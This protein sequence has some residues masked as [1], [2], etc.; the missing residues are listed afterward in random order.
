MKDKG[1][2]TLFSGIAKTLRKHSPEVL[3]GIGIAGMVSS[4]VL[5]V[6][7]TPKAMKLIEKKKSEN[8]TEKIKPVEVFKTSW[9]CYIPTAALLVVSASCLIGAASVNSRRRAAL[10]AAFT[11]SE[12]ARKEYGDKVVELFGEK[13]D[14]AV[15]DAVAKDRIEKDPVKTNEIIITEHGGTLCYDAVSGRYFRSDMEKLKKAGNELNRK[16]LTENYVSLNEFYYEIGLDDIGI[17]N[18][19]GWNIDKGEL[20]ELQFSS[21]LS[22]DGTPCLVLG[23]SV[24]P[25]YD[26]TWEHA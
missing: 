23:F 5:A 16:L 17:G 1:M 2:K 26:Y 14:Q 22:S 10:A 15:K 11:L 21:Q 6:R 7:A 9:H 4:V 25:H 12:S 20:V 8:E 13:K 19:I 3:T 24:V 18:D